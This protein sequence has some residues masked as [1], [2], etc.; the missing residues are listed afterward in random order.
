MWTHPLDTPTYLKH[1]LNYRKFYRW[2]LTRNFEKLNSRGSQPVSLLNVMMDLKKCCNHPYL[3]PT[4]SQVWAHG[5][6]M[7][8]MWVWLILGGTTH[9]GWILP[10]QGADPSIWQVHYLG[11]NDEASQGAR[12]QSTHLL[13]GLMITQYTIWCASF[14][15]CVY[16]YY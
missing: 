7:S 5:H 11:E 14:R 13:T 10:R 8:L 1:Y 9:T 2:I 15:I 16:S 12:S 3:F 6:E 4:A